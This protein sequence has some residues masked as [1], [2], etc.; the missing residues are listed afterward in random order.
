MLK[1]V[2]FFRG[3]HQYQVVSYNTVIDELG[4]CYKCLTMTTSF[5]WQIMLAQ[6]NA[7]LHK[8]A[9]LRSASCFAL[10]ITIS[11]LQRSRPHLVK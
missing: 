2:Y 9:S 4:W 10:V 5:D 6:G 7:Y 3:C 11:R 8:D 1:L